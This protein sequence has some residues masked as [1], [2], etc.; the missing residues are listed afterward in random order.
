MG[1]QAPV[2]KVNIGSLLVGVYV[3]VV[4]VDVAV[5]QAQTSSWSV[6]LQPEAL[7]Q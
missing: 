2:S 3:I 7:F 1:L 5:N 4:E 6:A